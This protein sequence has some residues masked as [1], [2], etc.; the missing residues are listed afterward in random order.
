MSLGKKFLK[1][2]LIK[3]KDL[4]KIKQEERKKRKEKKKEKG[5][6]QDS[7]P[8]EV[9]A[10]PTPSPLPE[11]P[12]HPIK[13][14]KSVEQ[15]VKRGLKSISGDRRFYYVGS[16]DRIHLANVS[17]G[18][19]RDL[20]DGKLAVIEYPQSPGKP[21]FVDKSTAKALTKKAPYMVRFFN[22]P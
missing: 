2:N 19:C 21:L 14:K 13:V 20:E 15:L 16:D 12:K 17:R 6:K 11:T 8:P 4:N 5:K 3:K 1:A 18:A 10:T 7:P 22:H 9:K